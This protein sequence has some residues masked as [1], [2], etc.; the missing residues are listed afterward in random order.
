MR[1][2][3]D[4]DYYIFIDYSDNLVG[5]SIIEQKK[6]FE[7]LP[8][9]KKF[10]HYKTRKHRKVYIQHINSTIKRE[11]ITDFF[12][13]IRIDKVNKNMDLFI[14]VLEFIKKHKNC[15]IFLCVDDYQFKKFRRLIH[16]IDG[17]NT[18]VRKESQLKKG[19]PEYQTSLVIDNL[20]NME[21]RKQG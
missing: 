5:Y 18:E 1:D 21:R 20:L 3:K 7:L 9:I 19:T 4:Y 10:E 13:K 6:I 16:L 12:E 2:R 15:I 14:E 17:D 8:K 11:K